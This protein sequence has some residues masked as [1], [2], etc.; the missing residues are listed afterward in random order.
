MQFWH[1]RKQALKQSSID[2]EKAWP[3][4]A[5]SAASRWPRLKVFDEALA[6]VVTE[7]LVRAEA[8]LVALGLGVGPLHRRGGPYNLEVHPSPP[9]GGRGRVSRVSLPGGRTSQT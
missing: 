7:R 4:W 3:A 8:W 2:G 6:L 5:P 9:A 1:V